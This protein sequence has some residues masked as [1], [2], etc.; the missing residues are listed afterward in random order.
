MAKTRAQRKA[1]RRK[2]EQRQTQQRQSEARD[3]GPAQRDT[4]TGVSGEVAEAE[5]VIETGARPDEYGE[6]TVDRDDQAPEQP[7]AAVPGVTPAPV[8][9]P[10]PE[11]EPEPEPAAPSRADVGRP[12]QT[13][14]Q[15]LEAPAPAREGREDKRARREREKEERRK[16]RAKQL[17]KGKP[18][19]QAEK[20]RGAVTGFIASCWAE[21]K[22]VQW[23]DR[24]TLVQASAVTLIFVAI[25]AAYL[26]ALD[27]AFNW[28]VKQ[29][30]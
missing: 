28:L 15:S 29:I 13:A 24:D 6:H 26:G 22:R 4:Q 23:P 16:A 17:Q 8:V 12:D 27:T 19:E 14:E 11:P 1:E 2:R 20:R 10:P 21:L 3:E 7:Q 18:A 5:A 9:P 25:A 30:L